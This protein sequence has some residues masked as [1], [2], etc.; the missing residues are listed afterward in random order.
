VV[1]K[2]LYFRPFAAIRSSVGMLIGPPNALECP[3]PMSVDQD[4]DDDWGAFAGADGV[5]RAGAFALRASSSVIAAYVGSASG[6]T[7]RSTV[8]APDEDP[9]AGEDDWLPGTG[10]HC[11]SQ[12]DRQ[13]DGR[14][15]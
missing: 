6:S 14:H 11:G 1:W 5:N 4:D 15:P 12:N 9:G 3:K 2:R 10:A 13:N 7:V 8:P